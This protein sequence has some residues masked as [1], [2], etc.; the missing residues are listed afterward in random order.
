MNKNKNFRKPCVIT[1]IW[2]V[3]V[4]IRFYN[5]QALVTLW[6]S[7]HHGDNF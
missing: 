4:S 1:V 6:Q 3:I 2:K 5:N 7:R